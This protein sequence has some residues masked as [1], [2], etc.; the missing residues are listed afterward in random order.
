MSILQISLI[1]AVVVIVVL[2]RIIINLL[3]Q[4]EQLDDL[5]RSERL[6][7]FYAASNAL[8]KMR[9]ADLRGSFESDD[10]VGAAFEDIKQVIEELKNEYEQN[11]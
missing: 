6:R 10:E 1:A 3:R 11:G 4:T 5:V 7:T 8:D 9:E 2:I